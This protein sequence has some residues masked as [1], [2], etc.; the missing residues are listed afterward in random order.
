MNLFAPK[1]RAAGVSA[2]LLLLA[3]TPNRQPS[4]GVSTPEQPGSAPEQPSNRPRWPGLHGRSGVNGDPI[5]DRASVEAF[6]A[7]R[8]RDCEIAVVYT[9]RSNWDTMTRNSSWVFDNFEGFPG[10]LVVSQGL[11]PD[12]HQADLASCA[13][14]EHDRDWRDFGELMVR[15]GRAD[16]IVRL[17]WEFNGTFMAWGAT[18]TKAWKACYRNAALA[19]REVNPRVKFDWT[20]NSHDTPPETCDGDSINCYPG[21]DVVDII[22][23]DNYDMGPSATSPAEFATIAAAKDGLDW[24]YAF[25]KKHRKKFSVGEWGTAPGHRANTNGENA[26]FIRWMNDWFTAHSADLA[27]EAYFNHCGVGEVESNL[28]RPKGPGC[29]RQ[30]H[31]AAKVYRQLWGGSGRSRPVS[32]SDQER[33][34]RDIDQG[35]Q[36]P[37]QDTEKALQ[38]PAQDT[39]R[40]PLK[41]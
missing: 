35:W 14:G 13:R 4:G 28:Y 39:D 20:V 26:H 11:V 17:G 9:D 27:Y 34:T 7:W 12:D 21:D 24:V 10:Q 41:H 6:C 16:S 5:I 1:L 8:G 33:P 29:A 31:A 38:G 3:C 37:T 18:D 15:K 36:D 2:A 40:D 32:L 30:N 25:A 22:G 23:I 19:I